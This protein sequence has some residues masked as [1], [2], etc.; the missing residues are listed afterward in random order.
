MTDNTDRRRPF[1]CPHKLQKGLLLSA[2]GYCRPAT[3]SQQA[4][5][6][7]EGQEPEEDAAMSWTH[8][9]FETSV[10]SHSRWICESLVPACVGC[11]VCQS[12]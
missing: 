10:V 7:K 11:A 4:T 1:H 2:V 5:R 12:S 6:T 9:K 3:R 8:V